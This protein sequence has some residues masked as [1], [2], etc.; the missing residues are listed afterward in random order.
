MLHHA[1][2]SSGSSHGSNPRVQW[3]FQ[4]WGA[5]VVVVGALGVPLVQGG[6]CPGGPQGSLQIALN[7]NGLQGSPIVRLSL[8]RCCSP[9]ADRLEGH[10]GMRE[11]RAVAL[12]LHVHCS[13]VTTTCTS[14]S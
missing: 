6:R 8:V 4:T 3:P 1:P 2:F 13:P 7:A 5:D 10:Y 11:C 12:L 9:C 14:A